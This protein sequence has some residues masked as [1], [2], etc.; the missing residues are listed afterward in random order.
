MD[1]VTYKLSQKYADKVAA[2]F[3]SVRVDGL[4]I[5][6]T[7]NDGKTATVTV[8]A[9][10]DGQ[11][12]VS[13][14]N[15][16]LN[17]QSHLI[18]TLSDGTAID[19]GLVHQGVDG[20]D[21]KDGV[22]GAPG[23]DGKDG[24]DGQ[25]GTDGRGIVSIEKT[26]TVGLVDTYTITYTDGTTSTF[27]VTN[28]SGGGSSYN[29]GFSCWENKT[30][31]CVG[32]SIT[33]GSGTT[34]IYYN[35]LKDMLNL[36][37]V[38]GMGVAGSCVSTKSNYGTSNSPL[39]N[40]YQNIPDKDLITIFMGTNDYGHNT[41][42]GTI[43]DTTDV[44]FYGAL[45][46]IIP[47]ILTAHP[48][49]RLVWITPTHRD[50]FG[51][52]FTHDWVANGAGNTLQDYVNAIKNVC[53]RY[54][55]PVIDLFEISGMNP[56]ISGIKSTYMPDGLH[57]NALGHNK[58]AGYIAKFLNLYSPDLPTTTDV[59]VD[60]TGV[61]LNKNSSTIAVGETETLT[62]TIAPAN[63]TNKN[64]TWSIV[65]GNQYVS[66]VPNGLS[67]S[68]TGVSDGQSVVRVTTQDGS[69]TSDCTITSTA[70][71]IDVTGVEIT[72]LDHMRYGSNLTLTANITPNNATNKNVTW[73]ITSGSEYVALTPEGLNCLVDGIGVGSADITVTTQDGNYS[74]TMTITVEEATTD[75]WEA[76]YGNRYSGNPADWTNHARLSP[77]SENR[78]FE[79]GTVLTLIDNVNYKWNVTPQ[80][81][82]DAFNQAS[83]IMPG[84]W[85]TTQTCT[86]PSSG[87]YGVTILN[88]DGT[89][90]DLTTDS[91]NIFDYVSVEESGPISVTGVSIQGSG[92]VTE[93]NNINL[94]AIVV[95]SNADDTDVSWSITSGNEYI[96]ISTNDNL[97]TV[98][99]LAA[100][101]AVVTVTT[102]D[103]GFTAS[104][105]ITVNAYVPLEWEL[106]YGNKYSNQPAQQTNHARLTPKAANYYFNAGDTITLIDNVTY[107]WQMCM[108]DSETDFQSVGGGGKSWQIPV[109]S[110]EASGAWTVTQSWT[111]PTSGYYAL[112]LL[113]A[114]NTN[115][116]LTT[117]SDNAFD[118][119]SVN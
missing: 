83:W 9:P 46:V 94:T 42:M 97:C 80:N 117:D 48:N 82:E 26:A 85:V 8:P 105:T 75:I 22:D 43:A 57:P 60:V 116:D 54:S 61:T 66:I 65:S 118:Y 119:I 4:D 72:G 103:G 78:Y 45:N 108:M 1:I 110:G 30:A 53:S 31:V 33:A 2:G 34:Q 21:G 62:A 102:D 114:N 115:F 59:T 47:G 44:S 69:F 107:K 93:G 56:V 29:T 13:I 18:C 70:S 89:D 15:V 40:R 98:T 100:G 50:G 41:P 17:Q 12:G 10:K 51:S 86:I 28:G 35:I 14:T 20:K 37:S 101:E 7:L 64:I 73:T 63:A 91:N 52:G 24:V 25:D 68:I 11:D 58:M 6:F 104:Q 67:C 109:Q 99:G 87:Y 27:T 74:D 79:A 112:A 55:V 16:S 113:K 76:D 49:S 81:S 96:S 38:Q 92:T 95:P 19:A 3:S 88:G 5:I 111:I 36:T 90:F 71:T 77:K 32:D 23:Q 84:G 106:D 39:I